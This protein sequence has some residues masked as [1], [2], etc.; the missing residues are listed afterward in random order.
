[1]SALWSNKSIIFLIRNCRPY[2]KGYNWQH[3]LLRL[4]EKLKHCLDKKGI[5]GTVL[6]DLSKAFD[7]IDHGFLIA[8]LAAYGFSND[9]LRFIFSHLHGRKQ[10]VKLNGMLSEWV[11]ILEGV[12]Q[13]SILGPILLVFLE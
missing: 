12:A 6:I 13:G 9:A 7:L 1:M 8:K 5:V 10:R 4:I 3:S 2:I 11:N